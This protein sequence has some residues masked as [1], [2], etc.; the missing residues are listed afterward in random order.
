LIQI[1]ATEFAYNYYTSSGSWGFF[2]CF[3]GGCFWGRVVFGL[4]CLFFF[5]F[6]CTYDKVSTL[7]V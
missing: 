2:G 4:L 6:K 3:E 5:F 7:S 1:S